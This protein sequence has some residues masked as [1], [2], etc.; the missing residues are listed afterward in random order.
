MKVISIEYPV[1]LEKCNKEKDNI[2]VFV[3]LENK[4]N[5]CITVATTQWLCEYVGDNYLSCGAPM[6]VV[7]SLD[8]RLIEKA[9][10][11]YAYD[12][13]YWLRVYSMSSG[14][15]IPD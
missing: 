8:K 13:A 15:N 10:E 5:Y 1:P 3:S 6:I 14:D 12:D 4:K 11:E 7:K 9:I 2:D